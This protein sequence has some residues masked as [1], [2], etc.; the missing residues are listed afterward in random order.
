MMSVARSLM[1]TM[2]AKT[3][4]LCNV[5]TSAGR[6]FAHPD[7]RFLP[8]AAVPGDGCGVGYLV[9]SDES[10]VRAIATRSY[11]EFSADMQVKSDDGGAWW[12]P[13]TTPLHIDFTESR[14]ATIVSRGNALVPKIIREACAAAELDV[15]DIDVLVTNQPNPVFLRNWPGNGRTS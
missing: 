1:T 5:Q 7:N 4:L 13:R 14:V 3:A 10:P 8:Q 12:A 6:V 11:G 2:G 15:E 9:A